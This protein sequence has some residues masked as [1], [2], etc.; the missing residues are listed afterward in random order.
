MAGR[1]AWEKLPDSELLQ[2]RLKDLKVSVEGTWL[3]TC[4]HRL[5]D[6]LAARDLRVRPHAWISDEWFSPDNTPGIAFPFYLAHPRLMRLERKKII[7]VEGGTTRDCMR[8]LRHEAGHVVQ[9]AFQLHRRRRW[10]AVFGRSS[11]PYPHYYRPN[12]ASKN[13]VQHLRLWY[14]Q[15]HPDEDFAETFAV[16]L[17]PRSD[18]RKRY[19]DWPALKKLEHVDELMAEIAGEKPQLTKRLLVDPLS[20]LKQTLDEHYARKQALYV[21]E[22]SS[23]YD[24]ELLKLFSADAKHRRKPLASTFLRLNRNHI[25]HVVARWTGEYQLTLDA[26][27]DS[28]IARCRALK[29]R[30]P[31]DQRQLMMDF[32]VLLTA[33]TVHSL[34]SP[35]RREWFAL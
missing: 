30:A 34:Y 16:W 18:W 35:S 28:M 11:T 31:G 1:F 21:S 10:Q 27:L 13:Y 15:S 17:R 25:R 6:E 14:A 8:I 12:P 19:A 22:T 9:H 20:T 5:Y 2:L 24:R 33:K 23:I 7:D 26:V 4:L 3:N 32:I 29:L